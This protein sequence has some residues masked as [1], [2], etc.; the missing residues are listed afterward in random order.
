VEDYPSECCRISS[1]TGSAD[2][3]GRHAR[4]RIFYQ[5]DLLDGL[6]DVYEELA[7]QPPPFTLILL[8]KIGFCKNLPSFG[9]LSVFEN[10]LLSCPRFTLGLQL[11][12][13]TP[14]GERQHSSNRLGR[15]CIFFM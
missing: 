4:S 6:G 13:L 10:V 8:V 3:Q 12:L 2:G 7:P 5:N 9:T 14:P 1:A 15:R 11:W